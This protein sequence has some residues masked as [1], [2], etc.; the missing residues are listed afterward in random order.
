[1]RDK[2]EMLEEQAAILIFT[3]M[4]LKD[5]VRFLNQRIEDLEYAVGGYPLEKP[6]QKELN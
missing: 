3:I 6:N 2:M 4:T 1:M 5:E